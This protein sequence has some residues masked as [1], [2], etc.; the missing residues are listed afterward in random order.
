MENL[1]TS[2]KL[3]VFFGF[4]ILKLGCLAPIFIGGYSRLG[5]IFRQRRIR[6][7]RKRSTEN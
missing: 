1:F 5:V 6:L 2:L 7:R 4:A 3:R